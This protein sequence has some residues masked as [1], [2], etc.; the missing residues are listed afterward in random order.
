MPH[1]ELARIAEPVRRSLEGEA[2][3]GPAV[4]EARSPPVRRRSPFD[5]GRFA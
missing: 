2:W 3:H 1:R 5:P 4:L